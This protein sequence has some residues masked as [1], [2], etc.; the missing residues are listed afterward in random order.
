MSTDIK[1]LILDV[2]GVLTD[3]KFYLGADGFESKSFHTQDGLGIKRCQ[4]AGITVAIISGRNSPVVDLRMQQ[5]KVDYVYQGIH[6]KSVI[7]EEL[8]D[9]TGYSAEQTACV[10]DDLPDLPIMQRAKL[11]IAVNNA[12]DEVLSAADWVASRD[13]GEGAVREICEYLLSL[14]S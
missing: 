13:G 6:D 14:E 10:G 5:L 7:F 3:G 8:L 2:D 11:G 12:V 9:K 4:Q 1:L